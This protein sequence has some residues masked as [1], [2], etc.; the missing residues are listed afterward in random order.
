MW[1]ALQKISEPEHST[2][3][4]A[5]AVPILFW[6]NETSTRCTLSIR[7]ILP[8]SSL[9]PRVSANLA[10]VYLVWGKATASTKYGTFSNFR[11]LL[12]DNICRKHSFL[13]ALI[14]GQKSLSILR[15]KSLTWESRQSPA[16]GCKWKSYLCDTVHYTIS[17]RY[18]AKYALPVGDQGM[19]SSCFHHPWMFALPLADR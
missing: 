17:I 5:K 3:L 11:K 15:G 4:G 1:C 6:W 10:K 2:V 13:M 18:V 8:S 9:T 16:T 12:E 14:S 7:N 19:W